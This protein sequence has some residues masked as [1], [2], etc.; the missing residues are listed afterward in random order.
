V[1]AAFLQSICP[2]TRRVPVS[3]DAAWEVL[4]GP[5][6]WD[7]PVLRRDWQGLVDAADNLNVMYQSPAW[8]GHLRHMGE[9]EGLALAVSRDPAGRYT[10]L[11]PLRVARCPLDFHVS[12]RKLGA[13][14]ILQVCFL[15]GGPLG[16]HDPPS[17]DGL[18]Q[19][20]LVAFPQAD[21]LGF[22]AIQAES[23]LWRC[24]FN[25]P[26][27][28]ERLFPYV[29]DGT[30][31]Y[32]VLLLPPTFAEYLARYDAK[33]RYN[34]KRQVRILRE[35]GGDLEL[36]RIENSEDLP[37]Y[38]DALAVLGLIS[39]PLGSSIEASSRCARR[40]RVLRSVAERGLLRSY[41]LSC[42]REIVGCIQGSQYREKYLVDAIRYRADYAR[43]SPGVVMLHLAIEDLLAHRPARLINFAFG[44]PNRRHHQFNLILDYGSVLLFRRTL[45]NRIR[46]A[47]HGSFRSSIRWVKK[48]TRRPDA[49]NHHARLVPS[50]WPTLA[51]LVSSGHPDDQSTGSDPGPS[52]DVQGDADAPGP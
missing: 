29:I 18:I 25:S 12:G 3:L 40:Y 42:G 4:S 8:F 45:A 49:G 43:F 32:H 30:Q 41:V 2:L 38:L 21:V 44:E 26:V 36:R 31:E 17:L 20:A 37:S 13:I 28:G 9:E 47:I 39:P 14:T 46:W 50:A 51:A 16:P 34:L 52:G 48:C 22:P 23:P 10:A 1:I 7:C 15:G 35:H 33:K 6:Q 24:L 27:I 11:A 5:D 19:A